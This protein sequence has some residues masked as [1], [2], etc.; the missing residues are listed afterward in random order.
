MVSGSFS[1]VIGDEIHVYVLGRL[2]HKRWL[3]T[4]QSVTFHVNPS[5]TS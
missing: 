1:V 2:V 3:K 4:G 5:G